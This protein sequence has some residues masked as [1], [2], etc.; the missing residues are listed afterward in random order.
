MRYAYV[1]APAGLWP[2]WEQYLELEG[3]KVQL[4]TPSCFGSQRCSWRLQSQHAA[5]EVCSRSACAGHCRSAS[6]AAR[7]FGV[8]DPWRCRML[9]ERMLLPQAP[10]APGETPLSMR[11]WLWRRYLRFLRE[12][13]KSLDM[14]LQARHAHNRRHFMRGPHGSGSFTLSNTTSFMRCYPHAHRDSLHPHACP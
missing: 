9:Y 6:N 3:T 11:S 2:L 12:S 8:Q 7:F 4:C 13:L 1:C 14:Q 10:D 5:A